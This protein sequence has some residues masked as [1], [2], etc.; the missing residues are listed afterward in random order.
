MAADLGSVANG[1]EINGDGG[2]RIAAA[3]LR[4]AGV[5]ER[6]AWRLAGA[7]GGHDVCFAGWRVQVIWRTGDHY[8]HDH[9]G[10]RRGCSFEGVQ[11]FQI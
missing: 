7:G 8:D 10:L 2:T 3:A 5:P 6:E 1:F 11:T 4:A 9:I